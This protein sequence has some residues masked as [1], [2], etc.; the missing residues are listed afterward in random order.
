MHVQ[1]RYSPVVLGANST[2]RINSQGTGGFLCTTSGTITLVRDNG[3]GSTTTLINAM[4]V[5][6]GIYYPLPFL[7]GQ[8]GGTFTTAGGAIGLLGVI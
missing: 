1:E 2:V 5:T 8:Y 3:G 7:L 4:A 6:A